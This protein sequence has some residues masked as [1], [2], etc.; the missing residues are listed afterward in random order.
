MQYLDESPPRTQQTP[1][2]SIFPFF[3]FF[4]LSSRFWFLGTIHDSHHIKE[5]PSYIGLHGPF[6]THHIQSVFP[7]STIQ[8]NSLV[9]GSLDREHTHTHRTTTFIYIYNSI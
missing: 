4:C 9:L 6:A 7:P 3:F 8:S 5:A 1:S 2:K